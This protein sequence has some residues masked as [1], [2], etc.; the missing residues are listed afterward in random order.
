MEILRVG[1]QDRDLRREEQESETAEKAF[2]AADGTM[3]RIVYTS[4]RT[5][6]SHPLLSASIA[7]LFD[8][9]SWGYLAPRK[10]ML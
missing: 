3:G 5:G 10:S 4:C 2:I 6:N 8:A 1:A 7:F 9:G